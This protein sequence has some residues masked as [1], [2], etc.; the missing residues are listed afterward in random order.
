MDVDVDTAPVDNTDPMILEKA[1]K[2]ADHHQEI[3]NGSCTLEDI[4]CHDVSLSYRLYIC[5][6]K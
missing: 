3:I 5:L 1:L 4:G 2:I 6:A